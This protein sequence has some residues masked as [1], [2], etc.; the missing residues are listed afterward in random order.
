MTPRAYLLQRGTLTDVQGENGCG[1]NDNDGGVYCDCHLARCGGK[2]FDAERIAM[3]FGHYHK[4]CFSCAECSRVS[5]RVRNCGDNFENLIPRCWMPG[6]PQK[7]RTDALFADL[8]IPNC[9]DP[10]S[11]IHQDHFELIWSVFTAGCSSR[12][13]VKPANRQDCSY[14]WQW[15]SKVRMELSP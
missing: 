13:R 15:L 14:R 2:V 9:T 6:T 7:R 10:R 8:A 12:H 4:K 3:D 1:H 5:K 11:E